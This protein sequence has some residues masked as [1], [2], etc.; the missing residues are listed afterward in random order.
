M[1][2]IRMMTLAMC[3]AALIG[4]TARAQQGR[5]G[6]GMMGGGGNLYANKSVQQELK[7]T[8][9]Q[10]EKLT[11]MAAEMNK[12][13]TE[14]MEKFADLDQ[15]E[16]RTKQQELA[17]TMG[18]ESQKEVAK[19]LKPEQLKRLNQIQV[20][21]AGVGAFTNMP[22]V[23]T[24]LKLTDEQKTK[25]TT[26]TQELGDE[27]RTIMQEMQSDRQGA[28]KKMAELNKSGVSKIAALL[29]EEQKKTW[30]TIIG[31][32]FE[33]KMEAPRGN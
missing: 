9:E 25:I 2:T 27:R 32:P 12:K 33:M 14:A 6:M 13:R 1:R 18:A 8:S 5:G 11:A 10:S 15:A 22:R 28:M 16:R 29:T 24:A 7:L 23:E 30:A 19:I 20:Q 3:A 4:G 26:I 21:T 17:R 31:A